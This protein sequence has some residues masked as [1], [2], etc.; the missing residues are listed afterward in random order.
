MDVGIS[1]GWTRGGKA[2]SRSLA[3]EGHEKA[4]VIGTK[5]CLSTKAQINNEWQITLSPPLIGDR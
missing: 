5:L 3:P 1:I 4:A 2:V